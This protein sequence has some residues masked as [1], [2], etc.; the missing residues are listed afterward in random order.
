MFQ[1]NFFMEEWR[2]E[3]D[4]Y[5]WKK[6]CHYFNERECPNFYTFLQ[7]AKADGHV[8]ITFHSIIGKKLRIGDTYFEVRALECDDST[9]FLS[10]TQ[11]RFY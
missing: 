3:L 6:L 10:D 1:K 8:Y 5:Q 4:D 11:K 9:T 7:S 2:E